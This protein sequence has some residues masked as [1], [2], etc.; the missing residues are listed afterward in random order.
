MLKP[1]VERLAEAKKAIDANGA[2]TGAG[3]ISWADLIMLAGKV[4]T[5]KSWVQMKVSGPI[6]SRRS[7]TVV[8]GTPY[9]D[10]WECV[11]NH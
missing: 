3:P 9:T 4:S 5:Q 10:G 2:K 8:Q 1:L 7:P 11:K 6:P